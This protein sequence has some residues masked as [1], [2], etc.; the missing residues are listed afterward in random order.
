MLHAYQFGFFLNPARF[1]AWSQNANAKDS[2]LTSAVLLWGSRLSSSTTLR[3]REAFFA[4]HATQ[5]AA[6]TTMGT[7]GHDVLCTIQAEVLLAHYFFATGR[8]LEG[9]YHCLAAVALTTASR[10]H[11]LNAASLGNNPVAAGERIRAFWTVVNVDKAWAAAMNTPPSLAQFGR[12]AIH[13][14]T[15]WPLAPEAYE[16]V[17]AVLGSGSNRLNT[18]PAGDTRTSSRWKLYDGGLRARHGGRFQRR[19]LAIGYSGKGSGAI[20]PCHLRLLAVSR[21]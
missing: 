12:A 10:F 2:A 6:A 15:P 16:Q 20:R 3:N 4:D 21:W 5:A 13:I 7:P 17:R 9:R 11:L 19:I 1:S 14:T 18:I 8:L